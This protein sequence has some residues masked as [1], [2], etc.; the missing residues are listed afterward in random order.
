MS[1]W[2][3]GSSMKHT[4]PAC[5]IKTQHSFSPTV[6]LVL[7]AYP[8]PCFTAYRYHNPWSPSGCRP[9]AGQVQARRRP[10][11]GGSMLINFALD[12]RRLRP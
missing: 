3:T 9:S 4:R 10:G 11:A 7:Y 1:A 2:H 6:S 5:Y 12:M 8:Q